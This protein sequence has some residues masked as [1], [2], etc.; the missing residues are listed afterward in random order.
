KLQAVLGITDR[1][2][3]FDCLEALANREGRKILDVV[4]RLQQTS[5]EP[6]VFAE[7]L[8]QELRNL[9]FIKIQPP[10]LNDL[11]DLSEEEMA[12]A[13]A[14]T[15]QMSEEEIHFLFDMALKG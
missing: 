14:L 6:K 9:L 1:G 11:V 10:N 2:I 5:L 15:E 4:E 8:L 3:L 13:V 12:R 7:S